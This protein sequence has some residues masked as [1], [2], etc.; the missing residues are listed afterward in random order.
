MIRPFTRKLALALSL[1][2]MLCGCSSGG[3]LTPEE[4]CP[5]S[6]TPTLSAAPTVEPDETPAPEDSAVPEESA[7]PGESAAPDESA[8]PEESAEPE[9]SAA[10]NESAV[11]EPTPEPAPTPAKPAEPA[12]TPVP[13]VS[14]EL[15]YADGV[16]FEPGQTTNTD[17]PAAVAA[18][19][20]ALRDEYFP[21]SNV[22]YAVVPD[23]SWYARGTTEKYF[24]H[25]QLKSLLSAGLSGFTEIDLDGALDLSSYYATDPHWRQEKLFPV[26]N[27]LGAA[28]DFKISEADFT[29]TA[30]E[31]F[32]GTYSRLSDELPAETLYYLTS[33]VTDAATVD[34][35]QQPG[36]RGVYDTAQLTPN[37]Y[38]VFLSGA[39]PLTVI[40]NPQATEERELVIFRDSYASS[41]APLLLPA[42]SR[43]TLVDLRYM[44]S[45]ML[46]KYIDFTGADVLF[47]YCDE[48]VNNSSLLK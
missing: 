8:A 31:G 37:G 10:P 17:S 36:F 33:A 23:K 41:L 12:P 43:I 32:I 39:T 44:L 13:G 18:K 5:P 20:M 42:C 14:D 19:L 11:P 34:N 29:K 2:L 1:A 48:L 24:D 6:P 4:S 22:Y 9:E 7:E 15:L 38:N 3:S 25:S 35:Y 16:Y 45:S 40:N 47:L 21:E 30:H 46:P 28:M 26:L 27:A